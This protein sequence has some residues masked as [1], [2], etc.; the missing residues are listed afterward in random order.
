[1]SQ[2]TYT[3][4]VIQ[5]SGC[6]LYTGTFP[7]FIDESALSC[8]PNLDDI[9]S[10]YGVAVDAINDSIDLSGVNKRCFSF[11]GSKVKDFA[12]ETI[13]KVCALETSLENL[14]AL[15]TGLN[16]GNHLITI[17]LKCLKPAA[18]PCSQGT[19]T[20]SLLAILNILVNEICLLKN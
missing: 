18:S 11:T 20:Y 16:I 19:D 4:S 5:P 6:V 7:A 2:K 13:E 8:I 3:C 12:E 17:D 1:M 14:S 10:K 9:F 15:I